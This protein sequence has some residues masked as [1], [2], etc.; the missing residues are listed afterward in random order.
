M[1][2]NGRL[3]IIDNFDS[4]TGIL[5]QMVREEGAGDV[6]VVREDRLDPLAAGGFGRILISPGPGL[7][8]DFPRMT[9][10]IR[11]HASTHRILGVCLGLQAVV[12]SFGGKLNRLDQVRHGISIPVRVVEAEETL[13]KGIPP[14]FSAGF[15]HSWA[16]DA[17][18]FPSVL[19]V[20]ARSNDRMIMAIR[21]ETFDLAGI[22][23]H[24]E[25]IMTPDGRTLL[26]NWLHA[27][28]G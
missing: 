11:R 17:D 6:V 5:A 26:R 15:Y 21:H 23:F 28:I 8:D 25:S 27:E 20:T 10:V 9:E 3:L 24:P 7:P 19:K 16:A 13:F 12:T 14:V 1:A 18:S 2:G 4:F 22:Q